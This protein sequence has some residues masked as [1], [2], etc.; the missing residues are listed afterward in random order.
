MSDGV[1]VEDMAGAEEEVFVLVERHLGV[2]RVGVR[3]REGAA[4]TEL[5]TRDPVAAAHRGLALRG[6]LAL[7]AL[8]VRTRERAGVRLRPD[9]DR[10]VDRVQLSKLDRR[11]EV[12]LLVRSVSDEELLQ[13]AQAERRVRVRASLDRL[14]VQRQDKRRRNGVGI[15]PQQLSRLQAKR[16][17]EHEL[18]EAVVA[19]VTHR[20]RSLMNRL[21]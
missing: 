1:V 15:D 7:P 14:A 20:K 6:Q 8:G 5:A 19:R 17:V 4:P 12:E 21:R 11:H 13:A 10:R 18:G 2:L 9:E 16:V 3:R